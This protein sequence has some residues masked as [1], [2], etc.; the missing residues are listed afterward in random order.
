MKLTHT[1]ALA[2]LALGLTAGTAFAQDATVVI[3]PDQTTVIHQYF[4][5]HK[6]KVVEVPSGFTV[7]VG[8]VVPAD[9]ELVPLDVP[10][11]KLQTTYDYVELGDQT[12][13]VDPS[14]RKIVQIL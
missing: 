6:P 5:T 12:V 4:T 14:T 10:D 9:V 2:T 3:S 11:L 7:A 8:A 13:I 1:L